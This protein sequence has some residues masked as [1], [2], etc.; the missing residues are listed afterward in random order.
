MGD[1][2][3]QKKVKIREEVMNKRK[4]IETKKLRQI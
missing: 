4:E 3:K 2:N 1:T